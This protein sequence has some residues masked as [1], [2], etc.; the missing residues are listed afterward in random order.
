MPMLRG[1]AI[2]GPKDGVALEAGPSWSGFIFKR[3]VGTKRF[4]GTVPATQPHHPGHYVW[5]SEDSTW[6]WHPDVVVVDTSPS[7]VVDLASFESNNRPDNGDG[8]GGGDR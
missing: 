5:C 1:K 3:G 8:Q 7:L 6:R 4:A 2:G